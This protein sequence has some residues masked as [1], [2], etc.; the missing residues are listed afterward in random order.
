MRVHVFNLIQES[1]DLEFNVSSC[2]FESTLRRYI[3]NRRRVGP[4][5][6]TKQHPLNLENNFW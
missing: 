5:G 3:T 4:A 1:L 2:I 6:A